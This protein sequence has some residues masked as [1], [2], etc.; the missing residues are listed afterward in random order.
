MALRTWDGSVEPLEQAGVL[1]T[2]SR[3]CGAC[4]EVCPVRIPIP[5]LIR[6]LRNESYNQEGNAVVAGGGYV[7]SI[8]DPWDFYWSSL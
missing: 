2:A 8:F 3:L 1:A 4:G 5:D 6:R 7:A